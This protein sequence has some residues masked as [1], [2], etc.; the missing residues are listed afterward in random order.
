MLTL[1]TQ[2]VY[3]MLIVLYKLIGTVCV[4]NPRYTVQKS[5]VAIPPHSTGY[6]DYPTRSERVAPFEF[7]NPE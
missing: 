6:V 4:T 2:T 1:V 7:L 5:S 3:S